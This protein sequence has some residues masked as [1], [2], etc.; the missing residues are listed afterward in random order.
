MA[1]PGGAGWGFSG[2]GPLDRGSGRASGERRSTIEFLAMRTTN[3]GEPAKVD[4]FEHPPSARPMKRFPVPTKP[5]SW[6]GEDIPK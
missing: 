3:S 4:D 2:G 1:Q 6:P 5:F